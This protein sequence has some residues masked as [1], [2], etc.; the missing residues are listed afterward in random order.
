MSF[1]F[2]DRPIESRREM[3]KSLR[4]K[5]PEHVPILI[6]MQGRELKKSKY[7]ISESQTFLRLMYSIRCEN[8]IFADQGVFLFA[9]NTVISPHQ[10]VL[11]VYSRHVS[12]DGF[13]YITVSFENTFG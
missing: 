12:E 5:Y 8:R 7:L 1:P 2:A 9:N 10:V 6:K 13:L 11:D 4:E 3:T